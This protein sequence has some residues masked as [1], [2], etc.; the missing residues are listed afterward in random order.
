MNDMSIPTRPTADA[1][2]VFRGNALGPTETVVW[3]GKPSFR[4]LARDV[5]HLR[6]CL[7]YFTA[8]FAL[9]AVQAWHKHL[10]LAKALHDSVPLAVLVGLGTGLLFGLAW[11]V[12]RTTFYT[13]TDARVILRYGIAM[14]ATL[15]L[16][17]RQVA[18]VAVSVDKLGAGD[19]A[20]RLADGNR[21][22]WIKLWP[23]A[24]AWHITSPQPMLRSIPAAGQ[25]G[26][27]LTRAIQAAEKSNGV[28]QQSREYSQGNNAA[29]PERLQPN[30]QAGFGAAPFGAAP[31]LAG[32]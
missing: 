25:V 28:E 6:G 23:L 8:L 14:Q 18:A 16:P 11:L 2:E 3:H 21:M 4:R 29:L 5:F 19:I 7:A 27:L 13:I 9:D 10:P 12:S 20:L 30:A 17:F 1:G 22:A 32:A 31:S 15:S 26:S 24:R